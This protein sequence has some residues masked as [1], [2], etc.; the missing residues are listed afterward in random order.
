MANIMNVAN[1]ISI[2]LGTIKSNL[3]CSIIGLTLKFQYLL[4][5]LK[6]I[7]KHWK[8]GYGIMSPK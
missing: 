3:T 8:Y 5:R 7:E 2:P 1:V 6:V 4:V